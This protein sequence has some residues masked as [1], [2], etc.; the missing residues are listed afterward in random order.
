LRDERVQ[1]VLH[2]AVHVKV[3]HFV[4]QEVDHP[5]RGNNNENR[6]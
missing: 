1:G 4:H 5:P 6:S 2:V 3:D